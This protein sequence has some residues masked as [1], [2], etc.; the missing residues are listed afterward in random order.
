L[1]E[2]ESTG[3]EAGLQERR[4]GCRTR[5]QHCS[6]RVVGQRVGGRDERLQNRRKER[7]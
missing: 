5:G 1:K 4:R 2:K 3:Q 6:R 7:L